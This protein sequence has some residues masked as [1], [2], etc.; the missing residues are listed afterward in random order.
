MRPRTWDV[1]QVGMPG[2]TFLS[3]LEVSG[4]QGGGDI[5]ETG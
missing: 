2:S 3:D 4:E 1:K 5:A